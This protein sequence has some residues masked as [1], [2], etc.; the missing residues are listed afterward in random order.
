MFLV[1]PIKI[2][3][4]TSIKEYLC[5]VDKI[6]SLEEGHLNTTEIR[7]LENYL[8]RSQLSW[9]EAWSTCL[10]DFNDNHYTTGKCIYACKYLF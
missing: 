10:Q 4:I 5:D 7:L 3:E 8:N 2:V 6:D 9:S 1:V